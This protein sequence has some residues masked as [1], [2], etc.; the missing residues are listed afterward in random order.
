MWQYRQTDELYHHGVKGMKWGYHKPSAADKRRVDDAGTVS[1]AGFGSQK[2]FQGGSKIAGEIGNL[3]SSPSKKV[4][5]EMSRMTDAEL[6]S[7]INRQ[8]M[9]QQYAA[10]NPSKVKRGAGV[11]KS[12]IEIAGGAAAIAGSAATVYAALKTDRWAK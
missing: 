5:E 1:K 8:T 12:I 4:R 7:K 9:E 3:A 10:L 11:A 6:R 2:G